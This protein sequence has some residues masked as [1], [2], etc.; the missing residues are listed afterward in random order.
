VQNAEMVSMLTMF[1]LFPLMFA[2]NVFTPTDAMPSWLKAFADNQ[3]ISVA[4]EAVRA[5]SDGTDATKSVM[6]TIA[7]SIGLVVVFASLAVRSYRR[8]G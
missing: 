4:T 1:W 2:S 5:L 3:P 6:L 7:W 8:A